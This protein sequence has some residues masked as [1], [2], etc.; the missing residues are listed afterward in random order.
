MQKIRVKYSQHGGVRGGD[1]RIHICFRIESRLAERSYQRSGRFASGVWYVMVV[2]LLVVCRLLPA[3]KIR[4]LWVVQKAE[5][6]LS[7]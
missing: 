6:F 3:S 1:V 2:G 5:N 4:E 7:E